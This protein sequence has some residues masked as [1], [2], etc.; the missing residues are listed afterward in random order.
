MKKTVFLLLLIFPLVS[1]NY[2]FVTTYNATQSIEQ[3]IAVP[4]GYKR[5]EVKTGS[6]GDW[7]RHLPLK[8]G[9]PEVH[10]YNGKL[11]ADQNVHHAVVDIDVG[12]T[13]LQQCAD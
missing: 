12:A 9:R 3:R 6:F 13:D 11:K 2:H 7:L 10:L 5:V 4:A 8:P 1:P